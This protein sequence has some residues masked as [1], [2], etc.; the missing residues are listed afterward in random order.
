MT[1]KELLDR[2]EAL[3]ARLAILE[4]AQ[5]ASP[6]YPYPYLV[7]DQYTPLTNPWQPY[8][9]QPTWYADGASTGDKPM[10]RGGTIC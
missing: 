4:A 5:L 2:I 3:E 8:P 10:P 1:K 6:P 7:G 9:W